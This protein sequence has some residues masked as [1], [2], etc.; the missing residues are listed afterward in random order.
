MQ[1]VLSGFFVIGVVVGVGYLM[2]QLGVFTEQAQNLL[3][4]LS[5]YV[6]MPVLFVTLMAGQDVG[7]VL[8]VDLVA[9]LVSIGA[10]VLLWVASAR[11]IWRMPLGETVAGSFASAYVNAGNL[12]L[13]IATYVL[14]SPTRAVP[15]MLTQLLFLQPVGLALLDL[16]TGTEARFTIRAFVSRFLRNPLTIATLVGVLLSVTGTRIPPLLAAPMSMV[17]AMAVPG[18][19]MAFGISLCL[20]PRPDRAGGPMLAWQTGLKLVAMPLVAWAFG[21]FAMHLGHEDLLAVTVMAGLPTAQNVFVIATRY[22]TGVVMVRDAIF[23]TTVLSV[24]SIFGIA[25]LLS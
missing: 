19:L 16:S 20:G 13:P 23:V 17:G 10:T 5:F 11:L 25:A 15:V 7:A 21:R 1:G 3:G 8:S 4:T 24:L 2:A 9:S 6:A 14:G 22:D 18:V 12:G